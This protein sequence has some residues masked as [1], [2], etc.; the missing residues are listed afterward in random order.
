MLKI[1]DTATPINKNGGADLG[2]LIGAITGAGLAY[3]SLSMSPIAFH[4]GSVIVVAVAF[5]AVLGVFVGIVL[6]RLIDLRL[7]SK[8]EQTIDNA[9][10]EQRPRNRGK[11]Q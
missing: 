3:W 1:R 8:V 7:A 9:P 4:I 6:G 5:G 11:M 2:A 10:T